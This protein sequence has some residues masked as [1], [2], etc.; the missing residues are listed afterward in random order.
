MH[1]STVNHNNIT[2][3]TFAKMRSFFLLALL[4]AAASA[5]VA[6][7]N[8]AVGESL[9]LGRLLSDGRRAERWATSRPYHGVDAKLIKRISF[10]GHAWPVGGLL[11]F[12]ACWMHVRPF[13]DCRLRSFSLENPSSR[14]ALTPSS[15][16]SPHEQ[17]PC[18][19]ALHR[20]YPT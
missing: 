9:F 6:P 8:K 20:W 10:P 11:A 16:Y 19:A 4:V 7:A 5:F 13:V 2:L 14:L 12:F 15:A 18:P 1:N 17:Q 3:S